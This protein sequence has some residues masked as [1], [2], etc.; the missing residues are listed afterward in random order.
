MKYSP[1]Y[2]DLKEMIQNYIEESSKT[3][4]RFTLD[5]QVDLERQIKILSNHLNN[6][7]DYELKRKED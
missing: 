1:T 6:L 4:Y 2:I 3:N 7:I 5:E